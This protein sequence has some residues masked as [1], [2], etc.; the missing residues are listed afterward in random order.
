MAPS[1]RSL[2]RFFCIRATRK[3]QITSESSGSSSSSRSL[4][5]YC[6]LVQKV[7]VSRERKCTF[8][9]TSWRKGR[10]ES[11]T[12][13]Q[14][15][16]FPMGFVF[17][18]VW[19]FCLCLCTTCVYGA[20]GGQKRASMWLLG[21]KPRSSARAVSNLHYGAIFPDALYSGFYLS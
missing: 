4:R 18:C 2:R 13:N 1:F 19:V 7:S 15:P 3:L 10:K 21:T 17:M 8:R 20:H 5:R 11:E 12:G 9:Y 16:L 14:S 6:G